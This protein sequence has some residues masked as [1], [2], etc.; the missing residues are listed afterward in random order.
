M[1][2]RNINEN[3]K[4]KKKG[5]STVEYILLFAGIIAIMIVFLGKNG[6]FAKA[7]NE[8]LHRGSDGMVNMANRLSESHAPR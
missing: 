3:Q 7:Y 2:K 4:K 5:Q 6:P 1:L 8:T